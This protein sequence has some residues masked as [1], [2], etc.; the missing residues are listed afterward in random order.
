MSLSGGDS[1][2]REALA[3]CRSERLETKRAY[4][5]LVAAVEAGNARAKYVLAT[6]YLNGNEI[7]QKDQRY[8]VVLLK[9]IMDANIAEASFDLAVSYDYGWG[10]R[11]NTRLA[12]VHYMKAALLG[13]REACDQISQFYLEGNY[14]PHNAML[15]KAWKLRSEQEEREISPP[16]RLWLE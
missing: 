4:E 15:S 2:Y 13:D 7:V 5:L 8:G 3:I 12:F 10:V 11:R 16:Y 9:Q 1:L 14:V 6:W